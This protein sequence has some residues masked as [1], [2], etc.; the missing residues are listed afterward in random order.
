MKV[1]SNRNR[2]HKLALGGWL[3]AFL[4]L[5]PV[6]VIQAQQTDQATAGQESPQ[7]DDSKLKDEWDR[8]PATLLRDYI[9]RAISALEA[10]VTKEDSP[11]KEQREKDDLKSQQD[12]AWWAL[13][14][15][16]GT[17][18]Q[19][20]VGAVGI[21]FVKRTLERNE[22][23]IEAAK[24]ASTAA[25]TAADAAKEAIEVTREMGARQLRAYIGISE[26]KYE[27]G[28]LGPAIGV[29]IKN[30]GQTPAY[31]LRGWTAWEFADI[32]TFEDAPHSVLRPSC[33]ICPG[34]PFNYMQPFNVP[35]ADARRPIFLWGRIDY[36]DAFG[37]PRH[38]IYR[39]YDQRD[40]TAPR[41]C[42]GGN[43][44]T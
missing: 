31:K 43:E 35:E 27:N 19:V 4:C 44:S 7:G 25:V 23:A 9:S 13:W 24:V 17:G 6:C 39:F 14:M 3:V 20:L 36:V 32:A 5:S 28:P 12:M 10:G 29:V 11:E 2:L 42:E 41:L 34:V 37:E 21:Y 22:E 40:G 30:F 26:T 33:D 38:T 15:V 8:I 18:A 1:L 16:I